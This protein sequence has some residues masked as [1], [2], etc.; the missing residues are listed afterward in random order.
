MATL[1]VYYSKYGA[2]KDYAE[3]LAQATGAELVPLARAKK[4]DLTAYEAI[5]FGCPY[6]M[7]QLKIAGFVRTCAPQLAGRRIAFFA[8]GGQEAIGP[9]IRKGYDAALSDEIRAGMRFFFLRGR[10]S[11]ARMNFL[12]RAVMQMMK[13]QDYDYTDRASIAPLVE[14]LKG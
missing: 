9:D 13:A 7:G 11:L 4:L 2:T 8:V 1:I 10:I 5:A 3:W 14:F 6:Y 12:E